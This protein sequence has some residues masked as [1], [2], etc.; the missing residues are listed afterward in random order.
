[1][2]GPGPRPAVRWTLA[3]A[4]F[5]ALAL[6]LRHL[7]AA[8]GAG[9]M[10][11]AQAAGWAAALAAALGWNAALCARWSEHAPNRILA[12][13]FLARSWFALLGL[14]V[15]GLNAD[16]GGIYLAI[17]S[18]LAVAS[19]CTHYLILRAQGR[20]LALENLAQH[21][22]YLVAIALAILVALRFAE[23]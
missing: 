13:E 23:T 2:A 19:W 15:V 17:A 5:L 1:M 4:P 8:P 9:P 6:V 11:W 18:G 20:Y 7:P 21:G 10:P 3:A 22:L 14:W 16:T 12:N